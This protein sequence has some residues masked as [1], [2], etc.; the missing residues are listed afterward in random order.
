[1]K[2]SISKRQRAA[3]VGTALSPKSSAMVKV[4]T[5][6]KLGDAIAIA[7][8]Q[9]HAELQWPPGSGGARVLK[10]TESA[11][12]LSMMAAGAGCVSQRAAHACRKRR[13]SVENRFATASRLPNIAQFQPWINH[14]GPATGARSVSTCNMEMLRKRTRKS[15]SDD[16]TFQSVQFK[17]LVVLE[18]GKLDG[19]L[20]SMA[21]KLYSGILKAIDHTRPRSKEKSLSP[22]S[23]SS[24]KYKQCVIT[25]LSL[26]LKT[27]AYTNH[28]LQLP[29]SYICLP[30][31]KPP[32]H[33]H[34]H[35]SCSLGTLY[36]QRRRQKNGMD[37]EKQNDF[38]AILLMAGKYGITVY[39]TT[40]FHLRILQKDVLSEVEV[41]SVHVSAVTGLPSD[42][43]ALEQH[44]TTHTDRQAT[45]SYGNF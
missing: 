29:S 9:F 20:S 10:A 13:L 15:G 43:T 3:K 40:R 25:D 19:L 16:P 7:V 34:G 31:A 44:Q 24:D 1:M 35:D 5:R 26:N 45:G 14:H 32:V 21:R 11:V 33:G 17:L 6:R 8:C 18:F 30:D 2:R 37:E 27:I 23:G 22:A 12:R 42:L 36:Q 41:V 38:G 39:S 28:S 4:C